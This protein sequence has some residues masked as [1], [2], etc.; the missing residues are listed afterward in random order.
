LA[1][2]A[3]NSL[4]FHLSLLRNR[5]GRISGKFRTKRAPR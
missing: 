3:D 2:G 1:C 5:L 4:I